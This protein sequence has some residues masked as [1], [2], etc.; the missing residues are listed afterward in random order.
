VGDR[1]SLSEWDRIGREL[2]ST[3]VLLRALDRLADDIG[4]ATRRRMLSTLRGFCRFLVARGALASDPTATDEL[5]VSAQ[6]DDDV[7]AFTT[8]DV[9]RLMK[10]AGDAPPN[11]RTRWPIR[12]QTIVATLAYCGL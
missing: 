10:A 11:S 12:D 3:D 7:R 2:G 4:P 5:R 8:A 6:A 9:A 1:H